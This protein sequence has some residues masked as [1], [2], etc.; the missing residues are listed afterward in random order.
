M[1]GS[2]SWLLWEAKVEGVVVACG[3]G[4]FRRDGCRK[5]RKEIGREDGE[6]GGGMARVESLGTVLCFSL[7]FAAACFAGVTAE[8]FEVP[9]IADVAEG[10]ACSSISAPS[11]ASVGTKVARASITQMRKSGGPGADLRK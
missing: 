9:L 7:A 4:R 10:T 3:G 6:G 11:S 1:A 5:A 2:V 8:G